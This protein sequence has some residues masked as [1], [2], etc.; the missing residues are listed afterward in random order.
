MVGARRKATLTT[1]PDDTA[2]SPS[3]LPP[4]QRPDA[5]AHTMEL[6]LPRIRDTAV[7]ETGNLSPELL[8]A[9]A[10][11]AAKSDAGRHTYR[12][13]V[14]VVD[15]FLVVVSVVLGYVSRFQGGDTLTDVPYIAIG[16]GLAV[17]WMVVLA[18]NGCYDMRVLGFGAE[19]L[20]R[21]G[22]ATLKLAGAVAIIAYL[23]SDVPVARGF[24]GISFLIGIALLP[25]GRLALRQ[26]L[27]WER[28]HDRGWNRRVLLV[29]DAGH[30][31]EL[32]NELRRAADAGYVLVGACIPDALVAPQPQQLADVPVVGSFSTILDAAA[33]KGADMVA[34][35]ATAELTGL[36]LR[37]LGW[38]MEGTG[39][40]LV[41]APSLIDVAG[42][43]I[44]TRPVA[45]LP[46]IHVSSPEFG[47]A[48]KWVK[49]FFDRA[50]AFGAVLVFSPVLLLI[51]A[52]IKMTTGGPAIF[53][54]RRVGRDGKEFDM[55]KFRSMV[56]GADRTLANLAEHNEANGPLFK[57]RGDPRV[58]AVGRVLR[59]FSLDELPQLVNVLRGEMSLVGPRPPLPTEVKRYNR[60]VARR[61]LVKPGL[62]GLWQVSGRSDLSWEESVRLDLYYVENWSLAAD[63]GIL[64][65]T[66]GAVLSRRGAY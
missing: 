50:G 40:D 63:L 14:A 21:V 15:A 19:E 57:I 30:V 42:P 53:R 24:L 54:Q 36:R 38:Q 5:M 35:T 44:H 6:D 33:A 62:T 45:G 46:L 22:S 43:R 7:D 27:H 41:L 65:K 64:W 16:A 48:G 49:D 55:W 26:R 10:G 18:W 20:R 29:G 4:L 32:A 34:I 52:L 2:A 61:L 8:N 58:T 9:D 1:A 60:D 39:I 25:V 11:A 56:D 3:P 59:R 37:R 13:K 12:V 66:L 31:V 23:V 47:G 17:L 51:A 28:Q